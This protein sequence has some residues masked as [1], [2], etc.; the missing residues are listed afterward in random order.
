MDSIW[1]DAGARKSGL[2]TQLAVPR[3]R[4]I[5]L[6]PYYGN[7]NSGSLRATQKVA[8]GELLRVITELRNYAAVLR[9]QEWWGGVP[10]EE[11]TQPSF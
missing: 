11:R 6:H 9:Y 3:G 5:T 7:L 8:W 2:R 10:L 1:T 4:I